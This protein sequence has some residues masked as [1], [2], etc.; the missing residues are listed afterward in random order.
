MPEIWPAVSVDVERLFGSDM[1]VE[2]SNVE[3]GVL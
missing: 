2:L 1:S 3:C